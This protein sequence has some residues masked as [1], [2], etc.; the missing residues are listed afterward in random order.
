M[1]NQVKQLA[2]GLLTA[3]LL[4][5]GVTSEV[6]THHPSAIMVGTAHVAPVGD[7]EHLAQVPR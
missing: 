1:I 3:G 2:H 5:C 6:A 4:G 7:S